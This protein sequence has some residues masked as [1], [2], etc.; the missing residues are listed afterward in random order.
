MMKLKKSGVHSKV[1]L[2]GWLFVSVLLIT[3]LQAQVQQTERYEMVQ[4]NA[5]EYFTVVSLEEEGLALIREKD[6][7]KGNKQLWEIII[8]DT[9]LSEK[10]KFDIEINQRHMLLG[11]EIDKNQL[12]LLFRTG[13]TTRNSLELV[14]VNTLQGSET[15][16]YEISTELDFKVT[17][18]NKVGS[19]IILG[20]YVTNEPAI[21]LYETAGRSIKVL[22]GFFQKDNELVELRVNQN[23]T[24][25]AVLMDR[26]LRSERKLVYK[27]FD[28]SGNLLLEDI[29]PIDDDKSLQ[30]SISSTLE[31][32]ELVLLGTW[33]EKQGKQSLGFFSLAVDPFSQQKINYFHFGMMENF[34]SYLSPKRA[35][36][37]KES[38]SDAIAAGR[39][40][41]FTTYVMP[42]RIAETP[43]GFLMLAEVY[44]PSS[45]MSP[46]YNYPYG[47]PYYGNPYYYYNPFS[48]GYFPGMRM[49]RPYA[50]GD[51]MRNPDNIKLHST[52]IAAFDA[53]GQL[54]WDQ[55][56]V[57]DE[58]KRPAL[59][60]VSDFYAD[61][62]NLHFIYKKESELKVKTISLEEG[63]ASEATEK[64]RLKA[65]IE[66]VRNEKEL[67]DGVR[68]WVGNTFY[69]WGYHTVRNPEN[70]ED[71]VRDVFYI[72]KIVV[73]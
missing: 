71:R 64:I 18:F 32:E 41:S 60:Q 20:G 15:S 5:D 14:E 55:S 61:G 34:L 24:F 59:E 39:K 48:P 25:N 3:P 16:R 26:S 21:L 1:I 69:V 54:L 62:E 35:E 11:Y 56:I 23:A 2:S 29:V 53:S 44:N 43:V 51:P 19:N 49:Y 37:I 42:F 73:N 68:H 4:K 50:Y 13:E 31:R 72:N 46:Y 7:Y 70:K 38:T 8:L 9:N 52:V 17:H 66:E 10:S 30:N 33:G 12:Y 6:K 65:P 63:T 58:M 27:T 57:L 22:P 45:N 36:K 28:A 67:E 40:P 47:H